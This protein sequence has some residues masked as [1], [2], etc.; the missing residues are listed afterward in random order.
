MS[1][2]L[3]QDVLD[4]THKFMSTPLRVLVKRD[5]LT[6]EV[7]AA[8]AP[9]ATI[10]DAHQTAGGEQPYRICM[11]ALRL[12][13]GSILIRDV[14]ERVAL[15]CLPDC[16]Q[17]WAHAPMSLA[18]E[19]IMCGGLR[20]EDIQQ[21]ERQGTVSSQ[22]FDPSWAPVPP[23]QG[24]KQFFVAVEKEEWK[25]D[26]LCDLYDTLTITQAVIFAN[27]KRKVHDGS[28][29]SMF[30]CSPASSARSMSVL[31]QTVLAEA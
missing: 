18:F 22:A 24:I 9:C 15:S 16:Q 26:T 2:T 7:R 20:G 5:E 10:F 13:G 8:G 4:M 25:F 3:P 28:Y 17:T 27:T 14:Q 31:S 11:A 30:T 29:H 6:L 19:V 21:H 1:A 12:Q 23:E